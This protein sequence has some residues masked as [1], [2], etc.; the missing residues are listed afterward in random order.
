MNFRAYINSLSDAELDDLAEAAGT[1]SRYIRI[2]LMSC[3]P[4][5]V[6]RRPLMAQLEK[7]LSG[8]VSRDELLDHF[9]PR[10]TEDAAA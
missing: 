1:S 5:R 7:A 2:H 4:R 3:P 8:S 9:Y 6:P 10:Q